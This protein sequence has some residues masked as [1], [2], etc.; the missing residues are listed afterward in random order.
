MRVLVTGASGFIGQ[1]VLQALAKRDVEVHAISRSKPKTKG[2][3]TWHPV[4]LLDHAA[5]RSAVQKIRPDIVLHL[6]WSVGSQFLNAP[7]NLDWV[8]ASLAIARASAEAG[9]KRLVAA[10]TCFEYSFPADGSCHEELTEKRPLTLYGV[11]K[12]ATRQ[13][14]DS[15]SR[16][17]KISFAW[18]RLFYLYGPHEAPERLIAS[19]ARALLSRSP[20]RCASGK[21]VRDYMDV[22]DAA[23]AI[24]AVAFSNFEGAI[25][26]ATGEGKSIA[27][28]V[29]RLAKLSGRPELLQLGALPDRPSEPPWIVADIQRLRE[30]GFK[31]IRGLDDGLRDALRYWNEP[32][33]F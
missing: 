30:L 18:T 31:Q 16:E 23:E 24:C 19:V 6:A 10:G 8:G 4:D 26:V 2:N 29:S 15:F 3:Y 12:N 20:A 22:R 7:V 28:I 33:S 9:V 32:S 27:E 25:N 5:A 21:P 14:L 17:T 1:A 13:I 11:T